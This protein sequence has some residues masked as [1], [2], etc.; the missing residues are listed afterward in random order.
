MNDGELLGSSREQMTECFVDVL[1][2]EEIENFEYH[3]QRETPILAGMEQV[4]VI[5]CGDLMIARGAF[6]SLDGAG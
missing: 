2:P 6:F 1:F 3:L 5:M 4:G